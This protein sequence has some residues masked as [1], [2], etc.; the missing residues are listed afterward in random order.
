MPDSMVG[1]FNKVWSTF[2]WHLK[3]QLDV[4]SEPPF[5][6]ARMKYIASVCDVGMNLV[7]SSILIH[8][9]SRNN[10]ARVYM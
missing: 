10:F 5:R 6:F 4:G 2:V 8:M 9:L 1:H 7:T 3:M